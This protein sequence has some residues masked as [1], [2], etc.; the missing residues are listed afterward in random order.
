MH[1][2]KNPHTAALKWAVTFMWMGALI[3]M[4][5]FGVDEPISVNQMHVLFL[6]IF[7]AYGLAFLMVLWNRLHVEEI[8][9]RRL[10]IGIIIFLVAI[11]QIATVLGGPQKRVQWPPYIPPFIGIFGN[12]FNEDE[13]ICSDMPWAVA[14]YSGRKS[15]LL[16]ATRKEF[17]DL[18]DYK[19]L[20]LPINGLYLTPLTRDQPLF[21]QIYSGRYKEWAGLITMPPQVSGF[22]LGVFT[23]L[24]IDGGCIIFSD[25]DRWNVRR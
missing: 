24:P 17:N 5:I 21:S 16:P 7:V 18:H 4:A 9:L 1:P 6:P 20:T 14:W 2:F 25:R 23:P 13:I 19:Q 3:G 8:I 12:W 10:F 22:P 15:L 11:P